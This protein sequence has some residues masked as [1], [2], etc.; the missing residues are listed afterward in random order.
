MAKLHLW[1]VSSAMRTYSVK[2]DQEKDL[3]WI[4][5]KAHIWRISIIKTKKETLI[6]GEGNIMRKRPTVGGGM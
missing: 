6:L 1:Q 4:N 5:D 3:L 2:A